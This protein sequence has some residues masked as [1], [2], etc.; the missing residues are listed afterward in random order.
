MKQYKKRPPSP[1]W[2]LEPL[3]AVTGTH[4]PMELARVLEVNSSQVHHWKK[5]GGVPDRSADRMAVRLGL[6]PLN[7]W[8]EFCDG[9]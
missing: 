7:V 6:H 1:R 8:P 2:P 5:G 4:T 9:F 3:M